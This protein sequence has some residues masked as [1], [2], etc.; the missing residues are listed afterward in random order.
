M[1]HGISKLIRS[2]VLLEKGDALLETPVVDKPCDSCMS[3]KVRPLSVVGVELI[4]VGFVDQHR[5]QKIV[6]I[7]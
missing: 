4:P 5:S 7:G 1:L 2:L 6:L 3:V